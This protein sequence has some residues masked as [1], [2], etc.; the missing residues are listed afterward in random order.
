MPANELDMQTV[1]AVVQIAVTPVFLLA[2]IAGFLNVMTSRLAR[3]ID[4][5]RILERGLINVNDPDHKIIVKGE[6]RDLLVRG[7][8]INIAITMATLSALLVCAVVMTLFFGAL[9]G[10]ALSETVAMLFV[11]CMAL[12]VVALSLFLG[13]VYIATRSMRSGLAKTES[14]INPKSHYSS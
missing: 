11:G 10:N 1:T 7:R 13:E 12:L 5:S 4:R 8:L 14:L 2:G 6:M 3:V 9:F